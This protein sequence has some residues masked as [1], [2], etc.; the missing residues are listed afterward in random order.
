[1][2]SG[3]TPPVTNAPPPPSSSD[4]RGV[5]TARARPHT[6][7]GLSVAEEGYR[8]RRDLFRNGKAT[9]VEVS[10]A[11]TDLTRAAS[12]WSTRTSLSH[13]PRPA[14]SRRRPRRP[15]VRRRVNEPGA[16]PHSRPLAQ[17][18]GGGGSDFKNGQKAFLYSVLPTT[19]F[20]CP[21]GRGHQT[22]G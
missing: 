2:E 6:R 20:V 11:Q 7:R 12:R 15:P 14:R 16:P 8:V 18:Y 3:S 5:D 19:V 17:L 9:F 21:P 13:R 1:M 4:G 10:D 22:T